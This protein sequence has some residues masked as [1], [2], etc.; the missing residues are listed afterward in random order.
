MRVC[1]NHHLPPAVLQIRFEP[2]CQCDCGVLNT[3]H[4]GAK[5]V[6]LS[7]GQGA[8]SAAIKRNGTPIDLSKD[9]RKMVWT[10]HA[11]QLS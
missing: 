8:A 1:G 5:P 2:I 10:I 7:A 9:G 11:S 6:F 3:L 4:G